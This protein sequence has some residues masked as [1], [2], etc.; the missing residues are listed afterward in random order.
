[1]SKLKFKQEKRKGKRKKKGEGKEKGINA[2]TK[3]H[4]Q[5][6]LQRNQDLPWN[7]CQEDKCLKNT[8]L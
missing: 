3:N 8:I 7:I 6:L 4:K 2:T 5:T 1:M